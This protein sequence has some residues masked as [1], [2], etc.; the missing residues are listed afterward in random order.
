MNK[1]FKFD[2]DLTINR[3][4]YGTMQ[5]PGSG[6]WG[7]SKDPENAV[8]VITTAIDN[9]VNFIDTADAYGPFFSNLYL[10]KA[11]EERPDNHVMVA[12]KVGHTRQGQIF[13]H[14][15]VIH[16]TYVNK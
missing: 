8:K 5:L 4:G 6:V 10:K 13:G 16:H 7:P 14:H 12:T 1:E 9:G 2:D 11:L 3:L 15:L